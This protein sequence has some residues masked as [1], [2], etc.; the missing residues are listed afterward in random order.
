MNIAGS[1]YSIT[2][3]TETDSLLLDNDDFRSNS[4]SNSDEVY[5]L[6]LQFDQQYL[7]QF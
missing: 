6:T 1:S 3:D 5:V 7:E 2:T 4:A